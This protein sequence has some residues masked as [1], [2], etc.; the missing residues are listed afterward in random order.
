MNADANKLPPGETIRVRSGIIL[1]RRDGI[2]VA[3]PTEHDMGLDD[4]R[5]V[6]DAIFT[7][8]PKDKPLR[9]LLDQRGM[10]RKVLPEARKQLAA[11]TP[12]FDRIAVVVKSAVSRFFATWVVGIA[13]SLGDKVKIFDDPRKADL[14]ITEGF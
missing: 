5:E 3:M 9:M 1:R 10:A 8:A 2:I 13:T 11:S 14:W 6:L 12:R 4:A 7:L